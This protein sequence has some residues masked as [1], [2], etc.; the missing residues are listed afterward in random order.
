MRAIIV[1]YI[2]SRSRIHRPE[3]LLSK[4]IP[5]F[6][7]PDGSLGSKAIEQTLGV[8]SKHVFIYKTLII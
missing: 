7:K 1:S 8:L 3:F 5:A 2:V 4:N 6:S